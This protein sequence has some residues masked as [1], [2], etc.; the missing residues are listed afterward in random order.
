MLI[1][2]LGDLVLA[3]RSLS[4]QG[5]LFFL[6]GF[7]LTRVH[8]ARRAALKTT[9]KRI[10]PVLSL[11][12]LLALVLGGMEFTRINRGGANVVFRGSTSALKKTNDLFFIS[13]SL[14]LYLT[15]NFGV[16]DQYLKHP[17]ERTPWGGNSFGPVYH[18]LEKLGFDTKVPTYPKFYMTPVRV[19]T[20]TYLREIHADFGPLGILIYPYVLSFVMSVLWFKLKKDFSFSTLALAGCLIAVIVMS[21]FMNILRGGDMYIVG[22]AGVLL[23]R[24]LDKKSRPQ[25]EAGGAVV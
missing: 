23:G 18:V 6:S 3:G 7:F 16:L 11:V 8:L 13:P 9:M 19:N 20:G 12:L 4:I 1:I 24:F 15:N 10:A 5:G 25:S 21:L 2:F 22:A 17:D 14:Y